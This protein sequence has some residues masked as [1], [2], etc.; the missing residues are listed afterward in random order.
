M[1]E[2]I[3]SEHFN[4]HSMVLGP[5]SYLLGFKI[6][7]TF[8]VTSEGIIATEK[9]QNDL[10]LPVR[11]PPRESWHQEVRILFQALLTTND[12]TRL[13][14]DRRILT[15]VGTLLNGSVHDPTLLAFWVLNRAFDPQIPNH[16]SCQMTRFPILTPYRNI[17]V[18]TYNAIV[19]NMD[20]S[21]ELI[22]STVTMDMVEARRLYE[23]LKETYRREQDH[24]IRHVL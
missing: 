3:Q 6:H 12:H 21:D 7:T 11:S 13:V 1:K 16:E 10:K 17:S 9:L 19:A 23:H 8:E 5:I 18:E 15:P 14:S 24:F 4:A 20:S 2:W 22:K